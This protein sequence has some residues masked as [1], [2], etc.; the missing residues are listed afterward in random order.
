MNKEEIQQKFND[1]LKGLGY[2]FYADEG[3]IPVHFYRNKNDMLDLMESCFNL[4]LE[5]AADN[6]EADFYRPDGQTIE[7]YVLKNSILKH[8]H[9]L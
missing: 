6:A 1:I 8:K 7:V 4:G 9:K 3:T 2:K 5:V